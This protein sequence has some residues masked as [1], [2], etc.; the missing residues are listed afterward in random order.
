[1]A[2]V[3]ADGP[4]QGATRWVAATAAPTRGA[5]GSLRPGK[6]AP[7]RSAGGWRAEE[8]GSGRVG[9]EAG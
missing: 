7:R 3:T 5:P 9:R 6:P 4:G 2:A 1:M 8:R